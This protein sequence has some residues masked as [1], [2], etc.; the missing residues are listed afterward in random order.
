MPS[1][2]NTNAIAIIR[3]HNGWALGPSL[4][5]TAA[6]CVAFETW[7]ALSA[8]LALNFAGPKDA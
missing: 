4:T 1:W 6:E 8:Y 2:L 7:E 3:T 5:S